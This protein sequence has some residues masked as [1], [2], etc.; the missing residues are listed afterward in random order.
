MSEPV[1]RVTFSLAAGAATPDLRTRHDRANIAD[2]IWPQRLA[3]L[4]SEVQ[5]GR[6]LTYMEVFDPPLRTKEQ[7]ELKRLVAA[8]RQKFPELDLVWVEEQE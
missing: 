6:V 8:H 5:N 7:M 1:W 2:T 4:R 3:V